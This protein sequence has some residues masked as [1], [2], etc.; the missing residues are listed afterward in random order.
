MFQV[1]LYWGVPLLIA[2]ACAVIKHKQFVLMFAVLSLI[3]SSPFTHI[4]SP[5]THM[6]AFFVFVIFRFFFWGGGARV[7]HLLTDLII[8]RPYTV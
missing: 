6:L 7:H 3:H 8:L 5:F 2:S 1:S 4:S